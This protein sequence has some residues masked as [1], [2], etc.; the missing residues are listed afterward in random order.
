M[1]KKIFIYQ[2]EIPFQFQIT[3]NLAQRNA[4]ESILVIVQD[5]EGITG[6]GE[7][8]PREYVTGETVF[9]SLATAKSLAEELS[10]INFNSPDDLLLSL[11][12]FAQ[13]DRVKSAPSSWCA[14]E[15]A[16]LDYYTKKNNLS[17]GDIFTEHP[18]KEDF[19]YSAVVPMLPISIQDAI[20][21]LIEINKIQ[22]VKLKVDDVETGITLIKYARE[23]LGNS[24]NI[25]VDANAAFSEKQAITFLKKAKK[26]SI[27]ALEQPVEKEN[28]DAFREIKNNSDKILII[29]D[30][31]IN[32]IEDGNDLINA[33]SCH[34]FNIR[35]SKCGG[36]INCLKLCRLA[37]E[38]NLIYQI[39]CHV[40][41]SSIL[42]AAGRHVASLCK[43]YLFL[44][45]SFSKYMLVDDITDKEVTFGYKGYAQRLLGPGLGVSINYEKL[46]KWAQLK[47]TVTLN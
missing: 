31:S 18:I 21:K 10:T 42:S 33:D 12:Y 29:A 11:G 45:G 36:I 27:S 47:H 15:T 30:E 1:L 3:H 13:S 2:L 16:I 44:E 25:R 43:D 26:F 32:T 39:G 23:K 40:G 28:L 37:K 19:E 38:N 6:C 8:T 34:G 20:F 9:K 5:D 4:G 7:G 17:L 41:E 22:Y 46:N 24:V 35:L 14:I